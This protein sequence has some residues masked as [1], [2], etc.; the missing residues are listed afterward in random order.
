MTNVID[1]ETRYYAMGAQARR[2]E[3]EV[4]IGRTEERALSLSLFSSS[5]VR[6][7]RMRRNRVE[8]EATRIRFTQDSRVEIRK[9][10]TQLRNVVV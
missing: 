1:V 8:V 2:I 5:A 10:L 6:T 7:G 9:T 4:E 3:C